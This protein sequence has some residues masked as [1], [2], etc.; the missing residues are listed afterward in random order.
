MRQFYRTTIKKYALLGFLGFALLFCIN[1]AFAGGVKVPL[2][3]TLG[4]AETVDISAPIADILI[5]D[6]SIVDV[7]A[8]NSKKLYVVGKAVGDTNVLLFDQNSNTLATLDVNVSQDNSNLSRTLNSFFPDEEV[9]ANTVNNNIVLSGRVS[10]PAKA[11]QIREVAG[12]FLGE[13]ET[14]L[15][16]MT[17]DGAQ[18]VLLKV[19]IVEAN[20]NILREYGIDPD[21]SIGDGNFVYSTTSDALGKLT[22]TPFTTGGIAFDSSNT[23]ITGLIHLLEEEGLLNTLAEPNLTTISGQRAEFLAGGEFPIP[24]GQSNGN[25]SIEFRQ[26]GVALGFTPVVLS[27]DKI[28]LSLETEVSTLSNE[29]RIELEDTSVPSISVRRALTTVELPSGGSLMIAGLIQ[30]ESADTMNSLP[31]INKIPVLGDLF[32]SQSFRR[33][34]SEL[35]VMIT[36]FLVNPIAQEQAQ[37]AR[38]L[39]KTAPAL[40]AT[41]TEDIEQNYGDRAPKNISNGPAAGYILD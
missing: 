8:L 40:Q 29:A 22:S 1:Q 15:D 18:Q 38:K 24:V 34:E 5:A 31:G 3:L 25:I 37:T 16:M 28:S 2:K 12:R 4:K 30:S 21:I 41:F 33:N 17:T 9:V 23:S 6:P 39:G 36:P 26:F 7:G 10:E 20:R 32:S 13:D 27:N 14:L 11:H 19:K 35:V